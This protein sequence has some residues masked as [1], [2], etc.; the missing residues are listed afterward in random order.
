ML[1]TEK[2]TREMVVSSAY[3]EWLLL[4]N[5]DKDLAWIRL[6]LAI[7]LIGTIPLGHVTCSTSSLGLVGE[8]STLVML[9]FGLLYSK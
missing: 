6:S 2:L 9:K 5:N 4:F 1:F 3:N 8:I 7:L